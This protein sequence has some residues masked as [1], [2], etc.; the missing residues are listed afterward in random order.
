MRL[1]CVCVQCTCDAF[2]FSPMAI[3][4]PYETFF[5]LLVPVTILIFDFS[6]RISTVVYHSLKTGLLKWRPDYEIACDEYQQ[7]GK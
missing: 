2:D 5:F 4:A 7:A 6:F 3:L 1:R